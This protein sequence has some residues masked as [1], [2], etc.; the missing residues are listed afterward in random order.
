VPATFLPDRL[1]SCPR[2][3]P[4]PRRRW[5]QGH[6]FGNQSL[7]VTN[8]RSALSRPAFKTSCAGTEQAIERCRCPQPSP[9]GAGSPRR[10]L[11]FH[12]RMMTGSPAPLIR[13]VPRSI[14]PWESPRAPLWFMRLFHPGSS[15]PR[16]EILVLHDYPELSARHRLILRRIGS[17]PPPPGLPVCTACTAARGGGAP[18]IRAVPRPKRE[19]R[20]TAACSID[21]RR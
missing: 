8:G 11:V 1:P 13:L 3:R 5:P 4:F 19:M 15:P 6:D 2:G 16:V 9:A 21:Q 10:R 18:T 7:A 14:F 12:R 17:R 20:F